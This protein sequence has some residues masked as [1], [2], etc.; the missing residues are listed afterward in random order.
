MGEQIYGKCDGC[1]K[2]DY[3]ERLTWHYPNVHCLCHSPNHFELR[4]YCKECAAKAEEPKYTKVTL[5]QANDE[6]I[7]LTVETIL[8]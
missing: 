6:P 4:F 5:R 2:E 7:I 1:G 3:L 8:L